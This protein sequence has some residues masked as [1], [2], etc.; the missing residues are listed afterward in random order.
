MRYVNL[1]A[2]ALALLL[3]A[4][5][6]MTTG[7]D[8]LR[9]A[10]TEPQKQIAL[11]THLNARAV[12]DAGTEP[13]SPAAIQVVE[14]TAASLG[15]TGM[16]ANPD[17][18]DYES[19]LTAA[20]TDAVKRPAVDDVFNE[21]DSGLGLLGDLAILFGFGGTIWGGKKIIDWIS[22][23]KQKSQALKEVIKSNELL[24]DIARCDDNKDFEPVFKNTNNA[25]QSPATKQIIWDQKNKSV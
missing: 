20:Q 19:T 17:I 13:G 15:Y 3:L 2:W 11:K 25:I 24:K 7:C 5:V 18:I 16:P 8:S 4:A 21:I 6:L 1:T 23:S 9:F 12:A 14:G 10:P 22:I